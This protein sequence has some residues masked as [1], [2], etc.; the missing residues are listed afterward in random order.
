M[1]LSEVVVLSA[2]NEFMMEIVSNGQCFFAI[3][4]GVG[5]PSYRSDSSSA[6]FFSVSEYS[7]Y[8]LF[9]PNMMSRR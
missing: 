8:F 4:R 9:A 7:R 3:E 2:S 6:L 1:Y 5:P